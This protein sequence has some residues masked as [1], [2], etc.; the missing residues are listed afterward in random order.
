VV[1]LPYEFEPTQMTEFPLFGL[2]SV[3]TEDTVLT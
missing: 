1:G 3:F 2:G